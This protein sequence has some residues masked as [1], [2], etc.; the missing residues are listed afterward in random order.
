MWSLP[1]DASGVAADTP[2]PRLFGARGDFSAFRLLSVSLVLPP[3]STAGFETDGTPIV[4]RKECHATQT[5]IT[6]RR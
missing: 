1:H 6:A 2:M 5:A 3:L 4:A